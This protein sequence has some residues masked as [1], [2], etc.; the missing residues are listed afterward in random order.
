MYIVQSISI[1][2]FYSGRNKRRPN[3]IWKRQR[4]AEQT[5]RQEKMFHVKHS[6]NTET[7][8]DIERHRHTLHHTTPR[9]GLCVSRFWGACGLDRLHTNF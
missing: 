6:C 8:R 3:T 7:D 5:G 1:I 4:I 9:T 2:I